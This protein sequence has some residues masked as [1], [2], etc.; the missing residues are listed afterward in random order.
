[1]YIKKINTKY[2]PVSLLERYIQLGVIDVKSTLPLLRPVRL[3]KTTNSYKFWGGKF[4]YTRCREVFKECLKNLGY[5]EKAFGLHSLRA[6]GATAVAQNSNGNLSER[7]IKLHGRWKTDVAK[8]M[9]ILEDTTKRLQI[10]DLLG[11]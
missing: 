5:D 6:G 11:I 10:T 3:F 9:Y 1:M 2:C 7:I 4:S 8:D